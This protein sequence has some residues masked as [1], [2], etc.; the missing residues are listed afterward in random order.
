VKVDQPIPLLTAAQRELIE[1]EPGVVERAAAAVRRDYWNLLRHVKDEELLTEGT[2]AVGLAAQT[3]APDRGAFGSWAFHKAC[4]AMLDLSRDDGRYANLKRAARAAV[5]RHL[6]DAPPPDDDREETREEAA[7]G[8]AAFADGTA[9]AI[10]DELGRL[11]VDPLA[12]LLEQQAVEHAGRSLRRVLDEL[13]PDQRRLL[14]LR[15]ADDETV[16]DAAKTLGRGYA[17]VRHGYHELLARMGARLRSLGLIEP[18]PRVD[19]TILQP[20]ES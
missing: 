17:R 11:P 4:F 18:P 13:P 2:I 10:L 14:D 1:S 15:F 6:Q 7:A 3:F 5:L 16:K 8:V 19:E 12:E 20:S 9:M